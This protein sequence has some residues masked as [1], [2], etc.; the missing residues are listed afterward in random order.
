MKNEF[1]KIMRDNAKVAKNIIS[2]ESTIKV[3]E[4]ELDYR[5]S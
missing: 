5:K 3:R 1:N 4:F 2:T